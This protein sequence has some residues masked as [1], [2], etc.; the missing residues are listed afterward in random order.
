L[1][2]TPA[3]AQ[4]VGTLNNIQCNK[5]ISVAIATA[6]TTSILT[7]VA[8]QPTHI[9]GYQIT[10]SVASGSTLQLEYGTQGGPCTTPTVFTGALNLSTTSIVNRSQY[11]YFSI[12]SGA[13]VCALTVGASVGATLDLYYAQPTP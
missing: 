12:P 8:N 11:A 13:Q 9:C 5:T 3:G 2:W 10:S 1:P 7:G 6:T 4:L